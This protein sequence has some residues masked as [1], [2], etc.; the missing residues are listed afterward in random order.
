MFI[1]ENA[2]ENFVW[3]MAA[4]WSWPQCVNQVINMIEN[5]KLIIMTGNDIPE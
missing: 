1:Q 2:F 5:Y 3:K 4:I